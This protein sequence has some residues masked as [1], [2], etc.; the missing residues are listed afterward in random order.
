MLADVLQQKKFMGVSLFKPGWQETQEPYPAYETIGAGYVKVAVNH[1]DGTSHIVLK[2]VARARIQKYLTREPYPIAQIIPL[3]SIEGDA[4]Q[5]DPFC[6]E[7]FRRYQTIPPND[8]LSQLQEIFEKQPS[9]FLADVVA[10]Y[11]TLSLEQKQA[12]LEELDVVQRFKLL[13]DALGGA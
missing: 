2:G 4:S 11:S 10:F 9:G 8:M 5:T 13:L 3:E 6:K 7:L 1:P 12:L